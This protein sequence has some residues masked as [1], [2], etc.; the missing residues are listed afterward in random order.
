VQLEYRPSTDGGGT[1]T[2]FAQT[3]GGSALPAGALNIQIPGSSK[4]GEL[5]AL[6]PGRVTIAKGADHL[7]LRVTSLTNSDGSLCDLKRL[8]LTPVS[9]P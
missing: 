1:A 4:Q 2:L 7:F 9:E 8:R 5:Q 6:T 3:G